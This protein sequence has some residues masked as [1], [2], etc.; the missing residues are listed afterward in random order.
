MNAARNGAFGCA[1]CL[2]I[3]PAIMLLVQYG[4]SF[5]GTA[6]IAILDLVAV[7]VKIPLYAQAK[8]GEQVCEFGASQVQAM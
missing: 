4:F 5:S 3:L 2:G 7:F 1:C 6:F 8:Q